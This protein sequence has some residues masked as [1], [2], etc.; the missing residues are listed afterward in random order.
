MTLQAK[1]VQKKRAG[2]LN[3]RHRPVSAEKGEQ[4]K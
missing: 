1:T 4:R 2:P 3:A